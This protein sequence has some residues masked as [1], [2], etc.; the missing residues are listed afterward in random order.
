MINNN[1]QGVYSAATTQYNDG[2]SI[3]FESTK[4]RL[5]LF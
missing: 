2:V 5:I 1:W 3:N 4:K